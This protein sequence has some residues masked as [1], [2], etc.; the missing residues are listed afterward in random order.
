MVDLQAEGSR[1]VQRIC[2]QRSRIK[3]SPGLCVLLCK[4]SIFILSSPVTIPRKGINSG[5]LF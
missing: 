4:M 1:G 5:S 2:R 3:I